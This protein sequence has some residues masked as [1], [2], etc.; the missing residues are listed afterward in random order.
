MRSRSL[1]V[2][3][4][5]DEKGHRGGCG[6]RRD[7]GAR[8]ATREDEGE[9]ETLVVLASALQCERVRFLRADTEHLKACGG[10]ARHTDSKADRT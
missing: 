10:G 8:E 3:G 6:D 5:V 2:R 7:R 9:R 1:L 4:Y